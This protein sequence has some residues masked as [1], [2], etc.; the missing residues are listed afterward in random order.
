VYGGYYGGGCWDCEDELIVGM[1]VGGMVGAAAASSVEE[2]T[3]T[4][5][6]TTTTSSGLPCNPTVSEVNGV[7][8]YQCGTQ[9]YV[10]AYGGT[11]PIYMPTPPPG[12]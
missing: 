10:Q 12:Q 11:G 1:V 9:Y 8:Y 3:T 2:E 7:T 5:T 6:T 4:T